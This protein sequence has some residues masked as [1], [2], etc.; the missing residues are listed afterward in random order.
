M[1]E[2]LL[3]EYLVF[4]VEILKMKARGGKVILQV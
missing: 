2:E 3:L 4:R 1:T